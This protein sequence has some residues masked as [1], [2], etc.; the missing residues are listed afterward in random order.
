MTNS[1]LEPSPSDQVPDLE[2]SLSEAD[3]LGGEADLREVDLR[4]V[5]LREAKQAAPVGQSR[6]IGSVLSPAVRLWL[7]SQVEQ[8]EDLQFE[9]AGGDRQILT[10]HIPEV[11]I[12]ARN[13]VYQGLHLSQI[14][15]V[16]TGIRINL[17]QMLR[18]KPLRLLTVVPLQGEL[19]LDEADLNAS[20]QAPL[21]ADAIAEFL[22]KLLQ[23]GPIADLAD[24]SDASEQQA[25]NLQN[26]QIAIGL[27]QL[28]VS[29]SLISVSGSETAIAIRTALQLVEGRILRLENPQWLP[30]ARAKRGLPLDD[31]HGFEVDLGP[32]VDIQTFTLEER[33]IA[34]RGR[35]NVIPA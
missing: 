23:S 27:D 14:Q 28:T 21:L 7:R 5:D 17:S 13:A 19:F 29:A 30:H 25:L 24:E 11:S 1:G 20:L 33:R 9:I 3:A 6:M 35:I 12:S 15:V 18:G 34:C 32:E 31:L 8:V 26:L 22:I 2:D 10:G 16:G 4:E